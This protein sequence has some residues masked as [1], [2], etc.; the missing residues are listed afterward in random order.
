MGTLRHGAADSDS[1]KRS[2]LWAGFDSSPVCDPDRA[3]RGERH[4]GE[5]M[6]VFLGSSQFLRNRTPVVA[7]K[8]AALRV[9]VPSTRRQTWLTPQSS[10][11]Q[12][13]LWPSRPQ[14]TRPC[15]RL[16]ATNRRTSRSC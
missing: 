13:S 6:A 14:T 1:A 9:V 8:K 10:K 12:Q 11:Q 5:E 7:E 15:P 3:G 4:T 16:T 2:L